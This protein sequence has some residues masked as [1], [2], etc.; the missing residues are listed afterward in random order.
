MITDNE[1]TPFKNL[2]RELSAI[3]GNTDWSLAM[4]RWICNSTIC[5]RSRLNFRDEVILRLADKRAGQI[6]SYQEIMSTV[7]KETTQKAEAYY[8]EMVQLAKDCWI[9]GGVI[10]EAICQKL[11]TR[12]DE[13]LPEG[14]RRIK[15]SDYDEEWNGRL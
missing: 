3:S 2:V 1:H 5:F 11:M 7:N 12:H 13:C 8:N 14:T 4:A 10:D 15:S 9:S 6:K